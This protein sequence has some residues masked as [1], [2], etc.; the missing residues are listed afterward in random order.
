MLKLGIWSNNNFIWSKLKFKVFFKLFTC[1][2]LKLKRIVF[3]GSKE[4]LISLNSLKK[5]IF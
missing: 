3:L 2:D 1:V 5:D 4:V